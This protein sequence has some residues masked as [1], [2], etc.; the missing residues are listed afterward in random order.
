[1]IFV[2]TAGFQSYGDARHRSRK[3][4]LDPIKANEADAKGAKAHI[5]ACQSVAETMEGD[6]ALVV[7]MDVDTNTNIT[8]AITDALDAQVYRVSMPCARIAPGLK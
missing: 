2:D 6:S 5:L 4:D 7:M 8:Q 3:S 1:M